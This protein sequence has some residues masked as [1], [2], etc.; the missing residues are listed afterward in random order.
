MNWVENRKTHRMTVESSPLSFEVIKGSFDDENE[1]HGWV[2]LKIIQR[3]GSTEEVWNIQ[4][5]HRLKGVVEFFRN[6][7]E[8]I[9]DAE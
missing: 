7:P 6:L 2:V 1:E 8:G 5:L 3:R 4:G 9:L